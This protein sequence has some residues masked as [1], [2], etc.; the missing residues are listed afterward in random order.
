M[1]IIIED[2]F[3]IGDTVKL[4]LYGV[5]SYVTKQILETVFSESIFWGFAATKGR[6]E[7]CLSFLFFI[8]LFLFFPDVKIGLLRIYLQ[9][10]LLKKFLVDQSLVEIMNSVC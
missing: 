8:N 1:L 7:G 9:H 5:V 3:H 6:S 2:Q 10:T 4:I